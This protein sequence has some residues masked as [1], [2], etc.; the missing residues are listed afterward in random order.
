[1]SPTVTKKTT[2][3]TISSEY[4]T[5]IVRTPVEFVPKHVCPAPG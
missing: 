4:R 5:N 1:V 2:P 3:P